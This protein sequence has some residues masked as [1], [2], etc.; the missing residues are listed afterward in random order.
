MRRKTVICGCGAMARG[1]LK[2]IAENEDLAAGIDVVGFVDL[3]IEAARA[4][5]AEYGHDA[6]AVGSDLDAL[7]SQVKP[8][9]LFDIVVPP[10]RMAVVRTALAH[11]CHVSKMVA[12]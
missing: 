3:D 5:A 6:A 4:L 7:L 10:A 12:P 9:M 1:W 8:E 11:G 2:A